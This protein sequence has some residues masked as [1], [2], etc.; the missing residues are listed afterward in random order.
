VPLLPAQGVHF[1]VRAAARLH[2][3]THCTHHRT[4]SHHSDSC[5]QKPEG[6]DVEQRYLQLAEFFRYLPRWS[7]CCCDDRADVFCACACLCELREH[8]D[9]F[10]RELAWTATELS[11]LEHCLPR[12]RR[13]R[14]TA[15]A[16]SPA[17]PISGV[18]E[19][20]NE[21]EEEEGEEEVGQ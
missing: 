7:R 3:T 13:T 2:R 18:E 5:R 4:H 1:Q 19:E 16:A 20:C 8:A 14:P 10:E 15:S 17:A 12:P 6:F 21:E 9:G 11:R